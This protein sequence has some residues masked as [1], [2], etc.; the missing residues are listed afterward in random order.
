MSIELIVFDL[1]GVMV[2]ICP[3]W[4]GAL[5][6]AGV[7]PPACLADA[8]TLDALLDLGH[9]YEVGQISTEEF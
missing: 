6:R 3:H 9:I 2:E 8:R 7:D 5:A 4:P 1:G